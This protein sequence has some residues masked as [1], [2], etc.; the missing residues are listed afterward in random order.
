MLIKIKSMKMMSIC[1]AI[2]SIE[3]SKDKLS[4]IVRLLC[5]ESLDITNNKW[6]MI[7]NIHNKDK[8][9]GH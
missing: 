5:L 4:Y 9:F 1:A 7:C 8:I 2:Y 6:L 3:W